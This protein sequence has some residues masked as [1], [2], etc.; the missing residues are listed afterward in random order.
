M[1]SSCCEKTIW[2]LQGV[3]LKRDGHWYC[4]NCFHSFRTERT[5]KSHENVRKNHDYCHMKI[6]EAHNKI[7]NNQNK[8]L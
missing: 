2:M 1:A 8:N 7:F 6:S 4:S 3:T 5:P